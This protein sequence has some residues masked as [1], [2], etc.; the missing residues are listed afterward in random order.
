MVPNCSTRFKKDLQ[1]KLFEQV[2]EKESG[3]GG[4]LIICYSSFVRPSIRSF[5]HLQNPIGSKFYY[6]RLRLILV[7][8]VTLAISLF[9]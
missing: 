6:L 4:K 9:I 5:V 2:M 7:L 1:D 3:G 8:E